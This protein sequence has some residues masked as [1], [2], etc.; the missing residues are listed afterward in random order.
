MPFGRNRGFGG[1]DLRRYDEVFRGGLIAGRGSLPVSRVISLDIFLFLFYCKA[2]WGHK[3]RAIMERRKHTRYSYL[4]KIGFCAHP[5]ADEA[6]IGII[7]DISDSGMCMTTFYPLEEGQEIIIKDPLPV[8]YQR[9]TI[10][11]IRKYHE[12]YYRVGLTFVERP[13]SDEDFELLVKAWAY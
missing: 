7:T 10:R 13:V 6:C 11:W 12:D 4:K 2:V 5:S 1:F 3:R 9:A 8:P